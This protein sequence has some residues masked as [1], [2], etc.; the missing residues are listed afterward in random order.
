MFNT[1][2]LIGIHILLLDCEPNL[3]STKQVLEK[4]GNFKVYTANSAEKAVQLHSKRH[5]DVIISECKLEG[6][7]GI[8]FLK[9][10]REEGNTTP[11]I[12][13]TGIKRE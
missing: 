10:F 2:G 11:F 3:T 1:S 5:F 13:L 4:M 6:K 12:I 8:Q 7:D 9:E